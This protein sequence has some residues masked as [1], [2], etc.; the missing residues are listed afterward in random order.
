MK[1]SKKLKI[2][3]KIRAKISGTPSR[4]RINVFRSNKHIYAQVIDD[5]ARETLASASTELIKKDK[6]MTKVEES[7]AVG[8]L[9]A[10]RM[11]AKNIETAVFDRGYYLYKGR[12]KSLCEGLR[13]T[14]III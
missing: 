8:V 3:K 12:V 7:K 2:R 5:V 13:E 4:P 1:I 14:G 6:K 11:K 10:N 9:L